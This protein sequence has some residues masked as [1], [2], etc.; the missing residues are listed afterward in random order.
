[1]GLDPVQALVLTLPRAPSHR[2]R[3]TENVL[4]NAD[5]MLTNPII[6]DLK[7]QLEE[8]KREKV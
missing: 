6:H 4:V 2:R 7:R 3:V 5:R 1:M 8:E